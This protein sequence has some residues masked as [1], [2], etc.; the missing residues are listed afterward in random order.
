MKRIILITFLFFGCSTTAE[1][2]TAPTGVEVF[3]ALLSDGGLDLSSEP[4]CE[5]TPN[6]IGVSSTTLHDRLSLIFSMSFHSTNQNTVSS[7]C[8]MSKYEIKGNIIDIWDCRLEL[9]ETSPDGEFISSSMTAFGL[10]LMEKKLVHGTLR[11]F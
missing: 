9:K 11:C 5:F 1:Q 8:S 6:F 7:S 3:A 2:L 10:S 4:L